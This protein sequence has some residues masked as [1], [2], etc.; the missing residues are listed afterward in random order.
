MSWLLDLGEAMRPTEF[1]AALLLW[2]SLGQCQT[3]AASQAREHEGESVTVCGIAQNEHTAVASRGKPTFIDLDST[4]P[5]QIFTVLVWEQDRPNVGALPRAGARVCVTGL[6]SYYHG[7][8]Q[9]VV[10]NSGQFS[11]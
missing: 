8:P 11:R 3:I 1:A 2:T 6:I 10:R 9:I 4:F 7:V 5:Y